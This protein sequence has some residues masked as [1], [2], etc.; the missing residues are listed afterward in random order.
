MRTIA[1][2]IIL[3][4]GAMMM[5]SMKLQRTVAK[6]RVKDKPNLSQKEELA[7]LQ[8]TLKSLNRMSSLKK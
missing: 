3:Q 7:Q 8:A 5:T 4:D 2:L 1:L 6:C